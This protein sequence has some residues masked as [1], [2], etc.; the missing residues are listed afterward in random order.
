MIHKSLLRLPCWKK[1]RSGFN[2]GSSVF[3]FARSFVVF[4]WFRW[5]HHL[6]HNTLNQKMTP[7]KKKNIKMLNACHIYSYEWSSGLRWSS[8]WW[9]G[10]QLYRYAIVLDYQYRFPKREQIQEEKAVDSRRA[11]CDMAKKSWG[12][13]WY[14]YINIT[15][16]FHDSVDEVDDHLL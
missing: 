14:K 11:I 15:I 8:R 6:W 12:N 16:W 13:T 1:A 3:G 2:F 4:G 10:L 9:N 7:P 5:C